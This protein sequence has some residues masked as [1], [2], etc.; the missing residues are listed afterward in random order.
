MYQR[1]KE[2]RS[3]LVIFNKKEVTM[4]IEKGGGGG[5]NCTEN[6]ITHIIYS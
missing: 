5:E 1:T 2:E 3:G 6:R 4:T